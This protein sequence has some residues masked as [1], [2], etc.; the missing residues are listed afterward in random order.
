MK[1]LHRFLQRWMQP[2]PF[3]QSSSSQSNSSQSSTASPGFSAPD[4]LWKRRRFWLTAVAIASGVGILR[5]L[6]AFQYAEL[7]ALDTFLQLRPAETTDQ[8]IVIVTI[9]DIDL[10]LLKDWP[11]SDG[12]LA[13]VLGKI[14]RQKPR[15][16]GL[17]LY[18]NLPIREGTAALE[19]AFKT[20]PH[21]VAIELLPTAETQRVAAPLF[22]DKR[23]IGFNNIV[24]DPDGTLRRSMMFM[25]SDNKTRRSFALQ[26]AL[27]YLEPENIKLTARGKQAFLGNIPLRQ[28]QLAPNSGGYVGADTAGIQ[29]LANPRGLDP[30]VGFKKV[31]LRSLLNNDIESSV[32]RDRVVLIGS[33]AE[34]LSD[35]V[36]I[37]YSSQAETLV[38]VSGVEAQAHFTSQIISATLDGRSLINTG[39]EPLEW[40]WILAW[41][42]V[43]VWMTRKIQALRWAILGV[44]IAVIVLGAICYVAL[45]QGWWIPLVPTVTGLVFSSGAVIIHLALMREELKKSKEFLNSMIQAI[46]DPVFVK[47]LNH[48]WVVLNEAYCR[49]T[50]YSRDRLLQQSNYDLFPLDQAQQFRQQDELAFTSKQ[51]H[52]AEEEL[53]NAEGITYRIATKRT[54]HVDAHGHV[55]L[56]GV[57]RDITERKQLE[58][59]LKRQADELSL[60]NSELKA[61]KDALTRMAYYDALTGLPNRKFFQECLAQA[62]TEAE[63]FRQPVALMF[64]DLDG[65]KQVNDTYGHQI[66]DLLLKAVAQR[67]SRCLRTSDTIARLGGDEFLALLPGIP[68]EADVQRVAEKILLSLSQS[69]ALEG[70]VMSVSS[71]IGISLYPRDSQTAE[72]LVRKADAAMY[73]AKD[74][75]KN[76]AVFYSGNHR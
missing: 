61:A 34:T 23:Q 60:S 66:G 37:S 44:A 54:V 2:L 64:I 75:G 71:S 13:Q 72:S 69:F 49:F 12:L 50:G 63:R 57:I 3:S 55:F 26:L 45:L 29:I 31:T 33:T 32:F 58:D 62:L 73:Q 6:N 19:Q 56:V 52:E 30:R 27:N 47:D 35:F 17:D 65:F 70:K 1:H 67:L 40:L 14:D 20:M 4:W 39:S 53:T 24:T 38:P 15:A 9:D 46:P 59:Q 11:L 25:V 18:R 68:S 8:R 36:N 74:A 5:L 48:H 43:G 16:I 41:S 22:A 76:R 7:K 21:L 10:E 51:P 28:Y 42:G